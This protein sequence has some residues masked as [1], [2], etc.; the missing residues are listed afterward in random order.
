MLLGAVDWTVATQT[1]QALI[2][3]TWECYFMWEKFADVIKGVIK[4]QDEEMILD[5]ISLPLSESS[6]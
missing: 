3:G 2:P 5:Y 6:F 1:H 4:T